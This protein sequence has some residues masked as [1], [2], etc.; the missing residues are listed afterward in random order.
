VLDK[1]IKEFVLVASWHEKFEEL[2]RRFK[3]K[4]RLKSEIGES[5]NTPVVG[6]ES[7]GFI[8]PAMLD[9]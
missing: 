3:L 5:G 7:V 6:P 4:P 2:Y 1:T 9:T 8:E